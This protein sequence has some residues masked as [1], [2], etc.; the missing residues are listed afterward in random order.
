MPKRQIV[1]IDEEKC[2]GCGLCVTPCAEGAIQ[3]INGKAKVVREELCDGAGFCIG[4]CPVGALSIEE[5][6]APAFSGEAV[7]EHLKNKEKTYLTQTCFRCGNSEEHVPLLP[8]RYRGESLWVCTRC[9]PPL[10]HG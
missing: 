10:I 2:T 9:L 8:C 5:R 7:H 3:I 6:E 4:V 1:R